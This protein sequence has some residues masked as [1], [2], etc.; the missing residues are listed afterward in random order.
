LY[1]KG[2]NFLIPVDTHVVAAI[3]DQP[4]RGLILAAPSA[5][6]RLIEATGTQNKAETPTWRCSIAFLRKLARDFGTTRNAPPG[7]SIEV[8]PIINSGNFYV[9]TQQLVV[10]VHGSWADNFICMSLIL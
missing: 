5:F 6:A 2:E 9:E 3:G 8:K 4:A 1:S 10:L 7:K